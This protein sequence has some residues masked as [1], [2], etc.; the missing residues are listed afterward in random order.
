MLSDN[1]YD[2]LGVVHLQQLFRD[3]SPWT[4]L[5][6]V[7]VAA[8]VGVAVDY[9]RMLWLRSKMVSPSPLLFYP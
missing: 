8:A 4:I 9:G 2:I 7:L 3:S 1:V 6:T 5:G